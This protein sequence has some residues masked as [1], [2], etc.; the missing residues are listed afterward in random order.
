MENKMKKL[1]LA[2]IG[3]LFCT[4]SFGLPHAAFAKAKINFKTAMKITEV[5]KLG[6]KLA[7]GAAVQTLV[8]GKTLKG[9]GWTWTFNSDGTQ[10]SRATDK[11]WDD[12]GNWHMSG[13]QL[14]RISTVAK[15]ATELCSNIYTLGHD[16]RM[17]DPTAVGKLHNWY[18]SY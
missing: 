6:G 17:T 11:S 13:N 16:L 10:A 8:S 4:A 5:E 3:V 18:L 15:A 12:K 14:C 1:S 9:K 7:D 2:A